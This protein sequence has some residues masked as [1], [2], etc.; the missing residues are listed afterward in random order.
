MDISNY[1]TIYDDVQKALLQ[2]RVT[3]A[4]A[5]IEGMLYLDT[6]TPDT[7]ELNRLRTDYRLM[8]DFMSRG[9]NDPQ[10]GNIQRNI[11]RNTF[12]L[13]EQ[14]YRTALVKYGTGLVATLL[15][16]VQNDPMC[17]HPAALATEAAAR[18][19][20]GNKEDESWEELYTRLFN[21]T[22]TSFFL[23]TDEVAPLVQ[24][25]EQLPGDAGELLTS[26]LFLSAWN[27]FDANKVKALIHLCNSE[28][29]ELRTRA[30]AGLV[31]LCVGRTEH[32]AQ[33]EDLLKGISLLQDNATVREEL[34]MIQKQWYISLET[35]RADK[36][37]KEEILPDLVKS[38]KFQ[39]T[40][41]G[42]EEV[43]A[44]L[45]DILTGNGNN[46]NTAKDKDE[47]RLARNMMEFV[48]MNEEGIDVNLVTFKQLKSF[49]FF[50]IPAN[51][52]WPFDHRRK[53]ISG[54]LYTKPTLVNHRL[55]NILKCSGFCHSDS[56]SLLLMLKNVP[57]KQQELMF[58][59]ISGKIEES[60]EGVMDKLMDEPLPA[61]KRYKR[62]FEDM[63]RFFKL[64]PRREEFTDVF[65]LDPLLSNCTML[66]SL[67]WNSD[68]I[69]ETGD[70]LMKLGYYRDAAAY[71]E[72]YTKTEN[73]TAEVLCKQGLCYQ[74]SGQP[75]LALQR[76]QQAEL[77]EPDSK[78]LHDR[79]RRCYAS[80]DM[81]E[82]ELECILRLE[83]ME[84]D[85]PKVLQETGLCL[86]QAER[87]EE[88]AN[89]FYKLEFMGEK[90]WA[91]SRAIAWCLLKQHKTVQAERYYARIIDNGKA[92]WVDYLNA[93][94]TAWILGKTEQ[95]VA[96][97]KRYVGEYDSKKEAGTNVLTPFH[98]DRKEL[99]DWG[100]SDDDISLMYDILANS[101]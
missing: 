99:L 84:P 61:K 77:L 57:I 101:Q 79:M 93:G 9:G 40:R 47:E 48:K 82:K 72:V 46:R 75:H 97:Y 78:W 50:K 19:Q 87:F 60:G 100:L 8:L 17:N 83:E 70:F 10:R 43:D 11:I 14:T 51:W 54:V 90:V 80:L 86:M 5:G 37:M 56:Y 67:V 4:L 52:F 69:R 41:M 22:F 24:A 91:A 23:H 15:R 55:T 29:D 28:H 64:H 33:H 32:L 38:K 20:Q 49:D 13:L 12:I 53:D 31:W 27:C 68:Y 94:H 2:K 71:W 76:Y 95:A 39:R 42:F 25:A 16:Q 66:K 89:R 58:D 36:K 30:L 59:Q 1:R 81:P 98:N 73:V 44:E 65:S 74:E 18:L 63:Y 45:T 35:V 26:A 62:L 88:A 85:N 92:R 34:V 7:E 96:F 21:V 6:P 3:D